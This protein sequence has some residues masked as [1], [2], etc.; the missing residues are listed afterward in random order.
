MGIEIERKFLVHDNTWQT[1]SDNGVIVRQ[2]YL[3]SDQDK[4]VRVRI[5]GENAFITIKGA[6]KGISRFEVEYEIPK[7]DA[8]EMLALCGNL[9][10]KTRY[11]VPYSGMI[12]ELD[13]F[14]G[15]NEGLVLAELELKSE[16]QVFDLPA[17]AGEEV[18]GDSRYYNACLARHPFYQ[19]AG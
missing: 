17:W 5:I 16:D 12:W 18:S 8:E 10:E 15:S 13:V 11:L 9:I 7:N 2:G 19:W 4:T 1:A 6:T 3:V 14:S